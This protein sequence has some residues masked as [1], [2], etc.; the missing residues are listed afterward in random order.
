MRCQVV[1]IRPPPARAYWSNGRGP[2]NQRLA[3]AIARRGAALYFSPPMVGKRFPRREDLG[4]TSA[5]FGVLRRLDSPRRIQ[6]FVYGLTQN[7][8]LA[9]ETCLTVREVLRT[10]RAHCIEGAMLAAC[11]LWVHGETP[12]LLDMR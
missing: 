5:E 3:E 10:R 4:L 1:R 9:G 2:R 7:F 8:E 6:D 11:A 12:L